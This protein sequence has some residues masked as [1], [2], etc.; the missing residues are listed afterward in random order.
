M[1]TYISIC[2]FV[3]Y[4]YVKYKT[5]N[6]QRLCVCVCEVMVKTVTTLQLTE[7]I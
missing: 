6:Y 7:V 1:I 4:A 2:I 3:Y 5:C